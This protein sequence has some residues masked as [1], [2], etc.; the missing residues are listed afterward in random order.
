[1]PRTMDTVESG[2]DNPYAPIE[3]GGSR[4][5]PPSWRFVVLTVGSRVADPDPIDA[6]KIAG[7]AIPTSSVAGAGH[8]CVLSSGD[9]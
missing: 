9:H 5:S 4:A 8:P 7:G 3:E 1:M 6:E 2:H